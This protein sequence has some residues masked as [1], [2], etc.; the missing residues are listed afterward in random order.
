[1]SPPVIPPYRTE[2]KPP[3]PRTK[4][5]VEYRL[6]ARAPHV[7][8]PTADL[9]TEAAKEVV[10]LR[11]DLMAAHKHNETLLHQADPC[12]SCGAS[13]GECMNAVHRGQA[14]CCPPCHHPDEHEAWTVVHQQ[15]TRIDGLRQQADTHTAR[16]D[17][18]LERVLVLLRDTR[19]HTV[20]TG[21]KA[22][23]AHV[24]VAAVE[25]ALAHVPAPEVPQ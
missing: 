6:H 8:Q 22:D 10:R 9:L 5:P 23:E 11:Q 21:G 1:V 25:H 13:V 19:R 2:T 3:A 24:P 14:K 16:Q 4:L 20:Q 17:A 12:A 18:R 15:L 7:D